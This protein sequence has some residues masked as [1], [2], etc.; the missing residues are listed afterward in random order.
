[1][2]RPALVRV[3]GVRVLMFFLLELGVARPERRMEGVRV[4][5]LAPPND[6]G[7]SGGRAKTERGASRETANCTRSLRLAGKALACLS[8]SLICSRAFM[9][10]SARTC[11]TPL[12]VCVCV[13][14]T[15]LAKLIGEKLL[16]MLARL[17][18]DRC[19]FAF[20]C[21]RCCSAAFTYC[22]NRL[23]LAA[24]PLPSELVDV[25]VGI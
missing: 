14:S 11:S 16:S 3:A 5:L 7:V 23:L 25:G 9:A 13:K 17:S 24:P 2:P 22:P 12:D 1:M 19:C 20:F 15:L 8:V 18:V 6:C 4:A 21:N 10:E